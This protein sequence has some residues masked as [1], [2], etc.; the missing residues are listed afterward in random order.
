MFT[1][2]QKEFCAK[3]GVYVTQCELSAEYREAAA[4]RDLLKPFLQEARKRWEWTQFYRT[5]ANPIDGVDQSLA[6]GANATAYDV[7]AAYAELRHRHAWQLQ[8]FVTA[9]QTVCLEKLIADLALPSQVHMLQEKLTAWAS[10]HRGIAHL[11]R[12]ATLGASGQ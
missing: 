11:S 8:N 1:N 12:Y 9:H 10:E 2:W 7:D 6:N 4:K 5:V 3:V